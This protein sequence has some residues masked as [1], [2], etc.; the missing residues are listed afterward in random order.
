MSILRCARPIKGAKDWRAGT[1]SGMYG[2][3]FESSGLGLWICR[4]V[5][6]M[7]MNYKI[8]ILEYFNRKKNKSVKFKFLSV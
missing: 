2:A 7:Q 5:P 4:P 1:L 8:A 3:G 6:V